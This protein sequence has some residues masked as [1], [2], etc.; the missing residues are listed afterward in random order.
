MRKL[1][2]LQIFFLNLKK[3][4]VAQSTIRNVTNDEKK[5]FIQEL[6]K[7]FLTFIKT[8]FQKILTCPR[9]KSCNF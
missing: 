4:R 2:V 1:K 5:S 3:S 9:M 7:N 8:Y 6:I